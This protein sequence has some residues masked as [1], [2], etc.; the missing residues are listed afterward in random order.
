MA[1][2]YESLQ[3]K[4]LN[5]VS[6]ALVHR[7]HTCDRPTASIQSYVAKFEMVFFTLDKSRD[8]C[9][10]RHFF[11]NKYF[12]RKIMFTFKCHSCEVVMCDIFLV[13]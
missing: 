8:S 1:E 13:S 12:D 2:I 3:H 6:R 7:G 5:S 9:S 10:R 4:N 11:P